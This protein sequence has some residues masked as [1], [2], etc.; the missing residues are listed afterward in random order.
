VRTFLNTIAAGCFAAAALAGAAYAQEITGAGAT[1][2]A[3]VYTAWGDA[4]KAETGTALNYQAIG[5]GGGQTQIT[6]RTV[7]FGASDAPM[8]PQKMADAHLLQFPAV[9]G[10]VVPIVNLPDVSDLTL[11][12]PVLADIYAG[13]ITAWND[14]AIAALNPGVTLPS[15]SIV[16]VY[17]SDASGTSFVWTTYLSTVSADWAENVGAATSVEWP[18]GAGAKGNDGVAGTV[19]NTV[20]A[21]GYVEYVYAASNDLQ[22]TKLE[23]AAGKIVEPSEAAFAAAAEQAD[24]DNAENMA[25]SMI[26]LG[27]DT[28]WPIVSA[29]YIL[30]PKDPQDATRSLNVMKF[31][32]WAYAN[33]GDK[34]K[35]LHYIMLPATVVDRIKK[36]WAAEIMGPD[37]KP[38]WGM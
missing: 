33:G 14:Q 28:T 27:G 13:K 3:P 12:G 24:W 8:D 11:S 2:P 10:A 38:V 1:F 7:D 9:I 31:F 15:T 16:P 37:G 21:V 17:R 25:A 6:N 36:A 23:N 35:E 19:K 20:G 32:E 5:S 34:A 30:L 29:T 4:Y 18:A 22:A 26:N